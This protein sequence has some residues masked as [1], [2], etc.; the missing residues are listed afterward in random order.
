MGY[1][2]LKDNHQKL[3]IESAKAEKYIETDFSIRNLKHII[4]KYSILVFS[5]QATSII[6][7]NLIQHLHEFR[8][9]I[10]H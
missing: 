10:F 9:Q 8:Q 5:N 1:E 3:Y 4:K 7:K 2:I 6:Y